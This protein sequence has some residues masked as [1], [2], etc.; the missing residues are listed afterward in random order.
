M[1]T[2]M[3]TAAD[4]VE[5]RSTVLRMDDLRVSAVGGNEI[6]LG[7]SL[8]L[9]RGQIL[10]LVGES[11]SGK[12]TAGLACMGHYRTGLQHTAGGIEL[13][14]RE[15]DPFYL[16]S[17]SAEQTRDL[18]GSRVAYIPQDPALSLNPAIRVGEQIREVLD[19]HAFGK[20]SAERSARVKE[21]LEDVGLPGT[22]EYQR[23]WP[24]QLSGGQQQRIGI[25]MAFAMFPDVLILDEP[26]T[27]L[28]VSTQAHVLDTIR[29]MTRRHD[30]ASLY[31]THDLAVV[32]ELAD[33]VAVMLRG[34]LVEEGPA[35]KVLH[36][37]EHDYTKRLLAA[38]P[39]LAG[40][41]DLPGGAERAAEVTEPQVSEPQVTQ[42][43]DSAAASATASAEPYLLQVS[44]LAMKFGDNVVLS[45]IDMTL[46]PGES[47]MIL[48]E[49]GSGKT[50]LSR[51][52]TGLVDGYTGSVRYRGEELAKS[53]RKR[54]VDHR[55]EIQYVFQ[56]PFSS[57]NPRRTIGESL[58][59]PL[60]MSKRLP[61]SEHKKAVEE[62]LDAVRLGRSF[63]DRRPGDLS[64]GER[65][66]AAIARA[67]V[68]APRVLVCDEIT[69]ALDVS[70]QASIVSLLN[71][72]REERGL[73]ILFVTHNITL[74]R[75]VSGHI[76]VLNKGVIVDRGTV[77][78]VLENPS[79]EYTKSL[80][81][82]IP[83]L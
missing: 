41:K 18:R 7:I 76:N 26:T 73:A 12:T 11:G 4:T 47:T 55:Q 35:E 65:Q 75:H 43:G 63:Y 9:Y 48:G 50:T 23:R 71:T 37:P 40:R 52:I 66:R 78:D 82:D 17:L 36:R 59:V 3:T 60:E 10:G 74:A 16:D 62:A 51:C 80:L 67:L 22:D 2:A 30:V 44:D 72:L 14:P 69:S 79:H 39:D 13:F 21:V 70:V 68:N 27:G 8:D 56:S 38:V 20:S 64:G 6:L 46:E 5:G 24:H 25:A 49:S 83:Q 34:E 29:D 42:P 45:S 57:L 81:S 28:D 32:A 31:I 54:T 61:R 33:R 15:G 77:E 1:S 58:T 19:V 53:T